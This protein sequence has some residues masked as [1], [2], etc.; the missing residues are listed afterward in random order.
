MSCVVRFPAASSRAATFVVSPSAS[1]SR[2]A[3]APISPTIDGSRVDADARGERT[4]EPLA[5]R[6]HTVDRGEA[7]AQRPLGVVVVRLRVAEVGEDAVAQVLRDVPA[8]ALDGARGRALIRADDLAQVL[9]IE[10]RRQLGRAHEVAEEDR[11]LPA[12]SR[13]RVGARSRCCGGGSRLVHGRE[14]SPAAAA[15]L[16][17]GLVRR[18]ARAACRCQCG[19][20]FRAEPSLGAVLVVAGRAAHRPRSVARLRARSGTG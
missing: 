5:Q 12:F 8:E 11:E 16:L 2:R 18:P 17:A 14:P 7:R 6:A 15:E 9:G 3:P 20:T 13:P 10:L 1:V 19:P 4:A